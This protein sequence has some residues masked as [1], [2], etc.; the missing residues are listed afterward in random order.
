MTEQIEQLYEV[1]P[2]WVS[3]GYGWTKGGIQ[4]HFTEEMVP[5][6]KTGSFFS[7]TV[8]HQG[9]NPLAIEGGGLDIAWDDPPVSIMARAKRYEALT[10]I[11]TALK[12]ASTE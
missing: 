11:A 10:R 2:F 9:W 4:P 6:S 8:E 5:R 3:A 7:D 1:T 12:K